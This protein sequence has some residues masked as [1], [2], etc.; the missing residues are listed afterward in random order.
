MVDVWSLP[1]S[2]KSE[3]MDVEPVPSDHEDKLLESPPKPTKLISPV[4]PRRRSPS[5]D[6]IARPVR[7]TPA[8]ERSVRDLDRPRDQTYTSRS[9]SK[10]SQSDRSQKR[11]RRGELLVTTEVRHPSCLIR[12][13]GA[14]LCPMLSVDIHQLSSR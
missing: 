14:E 2:S 10:D 3:E 12:G 13:F 5:P 1:S 8:R 7:R 9:R 4:R 6:K 11:V